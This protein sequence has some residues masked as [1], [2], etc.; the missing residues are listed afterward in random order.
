MAR[1]LRVIEAFVDQDE[2]G[3]RELA[4]ATGISVSASQRTL[5]D[6]H[7]LGLL[8]RTSGSGRYRVGP[9]LTRIAM[10]L[11][12]RLDIVQLAR[13]TLERAA[14]EL[15][16]TVVLVLYSPTRHQIWAADAVESDHPIRY[17]WESLRSWSDIHLG[18]S[19]K[20]VLAFLPDDERRDVLDQ[21][22]MRG[23]F[24]SDPAR[25]RL[26][27]AD[28]DEAGRRGYVISQGERFAGAIGVSAPIRDAAGRVVGA[29]VGAWPD[30]RT[31]QD[32][33]RSAARL[34]VRSASDVS[35]DLGF[36]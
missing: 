10:L 16:E 34:M 8:S 19:G 14:S 3:V 5:I 36:R 20:G 29:L 22:D 25:M 28:L 13:P 30:N 11:A 18:A 24:G 31:S 21:L 27:E 33:E 17:I 15:G 23:D 35:R 1:W 2:W 12:D 32:K 4:T 26:L 9:E 6:M 7:R